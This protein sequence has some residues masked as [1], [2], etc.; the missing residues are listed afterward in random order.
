MPVDEEFLLYPADTGEDP[1][2]LECG[3]TMVLATRGARQG[4]PDFVI[5]RCEH[6]GRTEKF[7]CEE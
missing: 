5:F 7:I 2:C 6:C 1:A 3:K 4:K